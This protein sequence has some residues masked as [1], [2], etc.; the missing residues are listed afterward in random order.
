VTFTA[1]PEAAPPGPPPIALA[2]AL[3][4]VTRYRLRL[5]DSRDA[6][7]LGLGAT[8][9]LAAAAWTGRRA[10]LVA[11]YTPPPDPEAAGRDLAMR[12]EHARRWGQERLQLQGADVCDVL[13]VAMRPVHGSL[14]SSVAAGERVR[15]GAAWVD[16]EQG[17]AEPLLP[18]PPDVPS[19]AELRQKARA[20]R[21]GQP[22][23][24]LAAVDLA[25]R[26]AVAGG[27]AAP[28]RRAMHRQPV[29]TYA[30]VASWVVI[31]LLELTGRSPFAAAYLTNCGAI[32][33]RCASAPYFI[34]GGD[35]W[36]RYI[37]S[38]FIHDPN[39]VLHLAFNGLAMF[40]IGRIVEQ[41]YGRLA[42]AATF[43]VTAAAGSL[44]W[45]AASAAGASQ[46]GVSF[47]ASG[48][49]AGL[50]GL[51]LVL[52]RVQGRNVPVG[53]AHGIRQYALLIIVINVVF[54]FLTSGVNNFAHLGGLAAGAG[55]GLVIPPL[56]TVG[57]RDMSLPEQLAL[58]ATIAVSCVALVIAGV[59][60]AQ[61]AAGALPFAG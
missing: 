51:L 23:P 18:I 48:G 59:D 30:F 57:G 35:D 61:G 31:Y 9:E 22:A 41:L 53:I 28:V 4:L 5:A 8:Y 7:L 40:W 11:F 2:V 39:D 50:V 6:R 12:C 43:L 52:G 56:R 45:V 27:Y 26:Q 17:N 32:P 29:V 38:A 24:T 46:P 47:G 44:L 15:V 20:L 16:A 42:L 36:W 1:P 25:E 37:S 14:S 54:G 13:I 60:W 3:E 10:A 49:I 33:V 21:G 58:G 34:S 19:V 55:I